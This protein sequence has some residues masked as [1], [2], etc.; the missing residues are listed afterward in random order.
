MKRLHRTS[1][2]LDLLVSAGHLYD[3]QVLF[4]EINNLCRVNRNE[5]QLSSKCQLDVMTLSHHTWRR[6]FADTNNL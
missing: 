4:S 5:L 1:N 2:F 3:L 6:V